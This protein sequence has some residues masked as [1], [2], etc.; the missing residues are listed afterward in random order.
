MNF[1]YYMLNKPSGYITACHDATQPTVM[2]LL[3][4]EIAEGLHPVGRL[5]I[6]T[7]GLLLLTDDGQLDHA[8]LQP[9]I[10]PARVSGMFIQVAR[11]P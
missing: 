7:C 4:Q 11:T 5:D 10:C 1:R 9:N 8:I 2:D 3:P 6:D